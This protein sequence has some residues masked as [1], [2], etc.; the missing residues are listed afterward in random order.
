M[1]IPGNHTA[2]PQPPTDVESTIVSLNSYVYQLTA[3]HWIHAVV[4]RLHGLEPGIRSDHPMKP[5]GPSWPEVD[6]GGRIVHD[7]SLE[8]WASWSFQ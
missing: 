1:T 3:S 7:R 8:P 6:L 2:S 5:T 4:E